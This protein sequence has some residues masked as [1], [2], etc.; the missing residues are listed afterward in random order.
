[1]RHFAECTN[2]LAQVYV[3]QWRDDAGGARRHAEL[4]L[5]ACRRTSPAFVVMDGGALP[6]VFADAG[7]FDRASALIE[8]VRELINGGVYECYRALLCMEEA[9]VA[10]R[11]GRSENALRCIARAL[12]LA[13]AD[14]K[15]ALRLR[16]MGKP[17]LLLFAYAIEAGV[18]AAVVRDL[19]DRWRV[20]APSSAPK[21]W[22]W[23]LKV[24][25]LGRFRVLV[26]NEPVSFGRKV[27]R[28]ILALLK[29]LIALGGS[30]VP[31]EKLTD[32]LWP[33]EDG[34]VA[35]GRYKMALVRLR[36]LLRRSDLLIQSGGKLSL[37][38]RKCWVDAFAFEEALRQSDTDG[39]TSAFTA[40]DPLATYQGAFSPDD[41][42]ASWSISTRERLRSKFIAAI[43]SHGGELEAA[44]DYAGAL[45]VYQ[46]G[47]QADEL[48]EAFC[49]GQ[50]R[51]YRELGRTSDAAAI[52][53][54]FKRL[55]SMTLGFQPAPATEQLYR[56]LAPW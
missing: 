16:Y 41:C 43:T 11:L 24:E 10:F 13:N 1:M 54:R 45:S 47:Q 9:Y 23:A 48:A 34:D 19:V 5:E 49:Q 39:E 33:D 44:A 32:A 52:Y 25:T 17:L 46:R 50:M 38:R 30:D 36:T 21:E 15:Q 35:H 37:D 56:S 51:C 40:A 55:L 14:M 26:K 29:A 31:E 12:R 2:H 53:Q 22:P 28:K 7:E 18:E 42:D 4:C 20:P 27:P 6:H 8:E 3:C